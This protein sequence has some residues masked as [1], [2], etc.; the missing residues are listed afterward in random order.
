MRTDVCMHFNGLITEQCQAGTQYEA[1]HHA[2]SLPLKDQ[3]PCF[4]AA[5]VCPARQFPT[6]EEVQAERD[7][8]QRLLRMIRAREAIE[9]ATGGEYGE[10]HNHVPG[11]RPA[12]VR[13]RQFQRPRYRD[14]Q[15]RPAASA[16]L[17]RKD[18]TMST[19]TRTGR[20]LP[21]E[22]RD[23]GKYR[24]QYLDFDEAEV[25]HQCW[26]CDG[27]VSF[28]SNGQGRTEWAA[29]DNDGNVTHHSNAGYGIMWPGLARR[30][31]LRPGG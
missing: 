25:L 9:A 22:I 10:R 27:K 11:L 19:A 4:N 30:S 2:G 14:L 21:Q 18:R 16:S 3:Y 7:V 12:A 23:L 24:F 31:Q 28:M 26:A 17:N 8:A 15:H 20:E 13:S 6:A 1:V 29:V 5:L